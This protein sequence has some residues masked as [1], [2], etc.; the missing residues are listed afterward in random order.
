MSK[1]LTADDIDPALKAA[2]WKAIKAMYDDYHGPG[3]LRAKEEELHAAADKSSERLMNL[4]HMAAKLSKNRGVQIGQYRLATE[5]AE[6]RLKQAH[7]IT[8]LKDPERGLKSWA[9]QKSNILRGMKMGVNVLDY[10]SE[11]EYRKA[12]LDKVQAQLLPPAKVPAIGHLSD[13][14]LSPADLQAVFAGTGVYHSF[15]APLAAITRDAERVK[16]GKNVQRVEE[17]LQRFAE[18][19]SSI[20]SDK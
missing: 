3:G 18:E 1:Q 14:T 9:V 13:G 6:E 17:L 2:A 7:E 19:L 12:V 5:L 4:A 15:V 8:N 10:R 11:Y 20:L 16:R